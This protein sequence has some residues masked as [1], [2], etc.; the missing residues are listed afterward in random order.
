[1]FK[2]PDPREGEIIVWLPFKIYLAVS[3][4]ITLIIGCWM[5]WLFYPGT[6]DNF[7][8]WV[9]KWRLVEYRRRAIDFD[10]DLEMFPRSRLSP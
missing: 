4:S 10:P 3:G 7:L 8:E 1:M 6:G 2:W 5:A 9:R